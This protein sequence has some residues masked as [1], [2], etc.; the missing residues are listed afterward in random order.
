[1]IRKR[2]LGM[3]PLVVLSGA[4]LRCAAVPLPTIRQ[5]PPVAHVVEAYDNVLP[6]SVTVRGFDVNAPVGMDVLD[7]RAEVVFDN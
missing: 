7:P 6:D 1:M 2:K 5:A 4:V 3:L